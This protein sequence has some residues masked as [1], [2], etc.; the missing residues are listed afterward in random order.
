MAAVRTLWFRKAIQDTAF[1]FMKLCHAAGSLSLIKHEG[2]SVEALV[3]KNEAI[4][5]INERLD[6]SSSNIS[7]GT[8]STVASIVS[9]EVRINPD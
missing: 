2:D 9:Y 8:L 6:Q 5:I 1:L 3:F 4:R 7:E